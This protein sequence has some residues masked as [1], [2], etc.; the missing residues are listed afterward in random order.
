MTFSFGTKSASG[1]TGAGFSF[2][3]SSTTP[4]TTAAKPATSGFSFGT[5]ATTAATPATT[6]AAAATGGFSFGSTTATTAAATKPATTGGF[7][8]GSTTA[9]AA[10][11]ATTGFSFGGAATAAA[12]TNT[13]G[14]S[15]NN[16]A[17]TPKKKPDDTP[18][19]SPGLG[20]NQPKGILKTGD[21][22]TGEGKKN[23]AGDG[24]TDEKKQ[25]ILSTH[26]PKEIADDVKALETHIKT[27]LDEHSKS[28]TK[29][30]GRTCFDKVS[31]RIKS[32]N[33]K[34]VL[35]SSQTKLLSA[36]VRTLINGLRSSRQHVEIAQ[37]TANISPALQFENTMPIRFFFQ[38]VERF[39]TTLIEYQRQINDIE[40][41]LFMKQGQEGRS[42]TDASLSGSEL[43]AFMDKFQQSFLK[44]AASYFSVHNA[45]QEVKQHYLQ[46]RAEKY[47]HRP[48]L[49]FGQK[50][51]STGLDDY[52]SIVK[53]A[54]L[55]KNN[56]PFSSYSTHLLAN[57]VKQNI[58]KQLTNPQPVQQ[59]NTAT[60]G[61][62]FGNTATTNTT[63][64]FS[65]GN[66]AAK[67][68]TSGFSFGNTSTTKP[69]TSGFSFGNTSA[70][71][72]A[73]T[74]SG[75]SFGKTAATTGTTNSSFSF[76]N[77]NTAAKPATSGFSF[78]F[79]K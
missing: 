53:Q 71:T 67:P 27:S 17:T 24:K 64:G 46:Y 73:G 77:T 75:F 9:A 70:A 23:E 59:T 39:H 8:F 51:K 15:F 33:S 42:N 68:A 22:Q 69:A 5:S 21:A 28:I 2:G 63:S 79:G 11:P 38:Q 37:N 55:D 20:G 14:F 40:T 4:A 74:T 13:T 66:T 54:K 35:L 31:D 1:G 10:K 43:V 62:L 50:P 12:P 56:M 25:N 30:G 3:A 26:V 76:G 7:S 60:G 18:K 41:A 65:F 32:S 29:C 16:L 34:V 52:T 19:E 61:G 44:V 47:P 45:M 72:T 78:N 49:K 6:S 36:D 58:A 57:I 48:A